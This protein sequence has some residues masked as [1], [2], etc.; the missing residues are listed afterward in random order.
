MGETIESLFR[1]GAISAKAG[2]KV[3]IIRDNYD[4][5][6]ILKKT[7]VERA[8]EESFE[9]KQGLRDQGGRMDHGHESGKR[10][11][12]NRHQEVSKKKHDGLGDP[13]K[14]RPGRDTG[15]GMKNEG[16]IVAGPDEMDQGDTQ[17]PDFPRG[18]GT[19]KAS[20]GGRED[21]GG[22]SGDRMPNKSGSLR[23]DT[24]DKPAKGGSNKRSM[25]KIEKQ[26]GWYGGSSSRK[27]Q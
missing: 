17:K 27:T 6:S 25:A 5:P 19:T 22:Y 16:K 18:G 9:G 10:D 2:K 1:R 26:G 12:L 21:T 15:G 4:K 3:G 11:H 14:G 23:I 8:D 13:S 7:K 20:R 24:R